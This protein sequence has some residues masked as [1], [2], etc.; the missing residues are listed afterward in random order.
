LPAAPRSLALL[1]AL[2]ELQST[3]PLRPEDFIS[4]LAIQSQID[5]DLPASVGFPHGRAA[6]L[7]AL[8]V[9]QDRLAE[10]AAERRR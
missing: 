9:A 10:G 6:G 1:L 4:R 2:P 7:L 3:I 8:N 5:W